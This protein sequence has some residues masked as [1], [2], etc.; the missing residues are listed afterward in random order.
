MTILLCRPR[1]GFNDCLVQVELARRYAQSHGRRLVLDTRRS[2]LH[3][4]LTEYFRPGPELRP[5]PEDLTPDLLAALD[6]EDSLRP[7][8]VAHRLSSYVPEYRDGHHRDA[9]TGAV[10]SFDMGKDHPEKVLLRETSGG[11]YESLLLLSHLQLHPQIASE[12]GGRILEL[13]PEHDAVHVRHSDY[14]SDYKAFLTRLAPALKRRPV[15][16]CTDSREV[17]EVAP[18]LLPGIDRLLMLAEVPETDGKPL[19]VLAEGDVSARNIEMLT[20][21]FALAFA[22]RLWFGSVQI[23]D[24]PGQVSGFSLLAEALRRHP[25]VLSGLFAG[26][27]PEVRAGL[28]ARVAGRG[29]ARLSPSLRMAAL[30]IRLTRRRWD[31]VL[32]AKIYQLGRTCWRFGKAG[33]IETSPVPPLF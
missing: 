23:G 24:D 25:K 22:R 15:L 4:Q 19:H 27:A 10:L 13:G 7:S 17:Q 28:E 2:G 11:G 5:A 26:A 31:P 30:R 9:M 1:G 16:L 12:I 20:D 6:A 8:E 21:L 32:D 14:R 33:L 29:R 18:G 3:A